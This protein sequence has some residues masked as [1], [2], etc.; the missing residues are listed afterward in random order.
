M[1]TR[2]IFPRN[3]HLLSGLLAAALALAACGGG[4]APTATSAPQATAT[5]AA[6]KAPTAVPPTA[7]K[8][9]T[10]TPEPTATALPEIELGDEQLNDPGGFAFQVVEGYAVDAAD[11]LVNMSAPEADPD[12]GPTLLLIGGPNTKA[13]TF[14][15]LFEAYSGSF[16]DVERTDT[17]DR[18]IGEADAQAADY[19]ATVGG[20]ELAGRFAF[21]LTEDEAQ[22]F[23]LIGAAPAAEWETFE[24]VYEAVLETVR[25]YEPVRPGTVLRQWASSA[26]A[27]SSFG[28]SSWTP[29]KAQ[30]EP[31]VAT[32]SDNSEAWASASSSGVDWLEVYYST[33]VVPTEINIYESYNPGQVVAVE[34]IGADGSEETVYSSDPQKIE[35]CPAVLSIAVE[36]EL[37]IVGV[38]VHVDQSV[39]KTWNEIDAVELVGVSYAES[40]GETLE[41]WAGTAEASSQFGEAGWSAFEA[42]GPADVDGCGDDLYAWASATRNGEDWLE[43]YFETPVHG[44]WAEIYQNFTPGQIVLVEA[45]DTEGG[46]HEVYA[47]TPEALTECPFVQEIALD[48]VDAPIIGLRIS[49]DQSQAN[50]WNE[51]DAVKLVGVP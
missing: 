43:V 41:Q 15:S 19:T 39:L 33:P 49:V 5:T 8:A 1:A 7:T 21:A 12:T 17:E 47:N 38:R 48:S 9:P 6:T 46:Y 24:R 29:D 20:K 34:L 22:L 50:N 27:S 35:T 44:A 10:N 18:A 23:V 4:A 36:T 25:L 45:I 3:T 30:G 16:S 37:E 42:T 32:C 31:N 40:S 28:S 11:G 13:H 51:I 2:M 14:D 26:Q